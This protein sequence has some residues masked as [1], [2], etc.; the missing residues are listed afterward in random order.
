MAIVTFATAL[1]R[2][3][4]FPETQYTRN[5]EVVEPRR[6]WVDK[7]RFWAV[8]GGGK[9]KD[10]RCVQ[11]VDVDVKD[12]RDAD[13]ETSLKHG[14]MVILPY[15]SHPVVH[16]NMAFISLVLVVNTYVLVSPCC[17]L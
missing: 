4:M 14:F 3:V 5:E 1:G 8:S 17:V 10:H 15:F 16:L 12:R 13:E 2:A 6:T 11:D 9:P 7:Y